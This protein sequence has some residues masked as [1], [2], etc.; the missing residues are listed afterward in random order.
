MKNFKCNGNLKMIEL[1]FD[2]G[3]VIKFFDYLSLPDDRCLLS[4]DRYFY[5]LS[6]DNVYFNGYIDTYFYDG[7][8][9][10]R[11]CDSIKYNN[12]KYLGFVK[13]SSIIV[14]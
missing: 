1:R 10:F 2:D 13:C 8:F 6:D 3:T 9:G 4:K 11:K 7:I 14:S 5:C 12:A